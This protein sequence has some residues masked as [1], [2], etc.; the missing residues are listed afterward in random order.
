IGTLTRLFSPLNKTYKIYHRK[1]HSAANRIPEPLTPV[2]QPKT[3]SKIAAAHPLPGLAHQA[4]KNTLGMTFDAL[5]LDRYV[6]ASV[7]INTE[8]DIL[9]FR[10]DTE[11]YLKQSSGK[12]S[13]NILKMVK[14]EMTFELRNAI[15]HAVKSR[16]AVSKEGIEL[17][18][19]AG[20]KTIQL[21]NLEV[22]PLPGGDEDPL[23]MV[24][25]TG[26][27]IDLPESSL[28]GNKIKTAARD[29]RIKKLEDELS[30]ARHDMSSITRDQESANEELQSANEEAVS[31][32]E[33]LQSLN[34]ELETSKEEIE[35][36]NE[37]LI[38]TNQELQN[39]IQEVE[40]L[41][42]YYEGILSTIQEPMLILDKFLRVKSVNTSFC[43]MF[44]V[45]VEESQGVLLY[46]LGADQWNI[47]RL[48]ELLEEIVP[49]NKRF[50]GFEVSHDFPLIG[51]KTML[52]NAHRIIQHHK[53]EELIVLT[54]TDITEVN[55]LALELQMKEK[56]VLEVE[57]DAERSMKLKVEESNKAL[58]EAKIFADAKTRIAEQA[59]QSKQ[60]FLSNMSHEIRTP[61]NAIVGF[62]NVLLKGAVLPGQKE[63]LHSIKTSA[64]ALT[65][66]IN[67]ILD[68]AKVDAGKMIFEKR[69]FRMRDSIQSVFHLFESSIQNKGLVFTKNVD[70][71]IPSVVVGDPVRLH[72]IMLNL[73]SNAEKFT[74]DGSIAV[75]IALL[76]ELA[77]SVTLEFSIA[78]TGIGIEEN[79]L[80]HI[81]KNFEQASGGT[82]RLY[83][84]TGLGL[85]I[86]KQLVEGQGGSLRVQSK[87]GA[88][89][90]FSFNLSYDKTE[91]HPEEEIPVSRLTSEVNNIHVLM[92]EDIAL[93]QLLLKTLLDEFGFTYDCASN[94]KIAI[95]LMEQHSYD[96]VL[97]DLHMPVMNGFEATA[98][99]RQT[100]QSTVP[101]IVLTADVTTM[102]LEKCKALGMDDYISK[103]I[104][105]QLLYSKIKSLVSK[106]TN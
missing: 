76:R 11:K 68:L 53:N 79:K 57:L 29:R 95:E 1:N 51:F 6:P 31:S 69:A 82:S 63:F 40:E 36:T 67:D 80:E 87:P 50:H 60:H 25:F 48:R 104:D 93:N 89:S 99:I 33:E 65:V 71:A 2:L 3:K 49:K 45:S 81:F 4:G 34:E 85:A 92:V 21:V 18:R 7:I 73:I 86:V 54:I 42:A 23:F 102:D 28:K 88:G 32:N 13:F 17:N 64:G 43:K 14:P 78:D 97:M 101:I 39:R 103:P 12:A 19:E 75:S 61:M 15:H 9:Q 22:I 46:K 96:I 83:G 84:G 38:T 91:A 44:R 26:Q 74:A 20:S 100:L 94:G 41:Y 106:K 98:Y 105:D 77:D 37:E 90:T 47:P 66:L 30:A 24:I 5:L 27:H 16:N 62:T 70:A 52:L 35:S 58:Q 8:M 55:R 56:R 10:G 59:V 72:Q